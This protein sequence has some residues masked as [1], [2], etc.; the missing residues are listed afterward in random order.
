[1]SRY[2]IRHF[3]A[4]SALLAIPVLVG[5]APALLDLTTRVELIEEA[6]FSEPIETVLLDDDFED[7][8]DP[9]WVQ[10]EGATQTIAPKT[11]TTRARAALAADT[12]RRTLDRIPKSDPASKAA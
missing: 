11:L 5:A 4:L 9:A 7:G 6:L 2:K 12:H 3:L 1:M 8:I 10:V